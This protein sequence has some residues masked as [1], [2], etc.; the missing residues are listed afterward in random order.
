MIYESLRL[1]RNLLL[2]TFAVGLIIAIILGFITIAAWSSWTPMAG[3]WFHADEAVLSRLVLEFFLTVRFF[4]LFIILAPA[5]AL[6]WTMRKETFSEKII[7]KKKR[8]FG[9]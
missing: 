7:E 8:W 3:N 4:L 6:H 2:R 1:A 9:K 5:L